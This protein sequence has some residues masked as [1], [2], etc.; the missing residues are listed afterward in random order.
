MQILLVMKQKI[1][2]AIPFSYPTRIQGFTDSSVSVS[3]PDGLEG[4]TFP[5]R[6]SNPRTC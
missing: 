5:D 2:Q 6:S 4:W 1:S 3:H